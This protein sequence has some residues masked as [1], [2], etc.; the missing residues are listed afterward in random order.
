MATGYY[1]FTYGS[2]ATTGISIAYS[3][4]GTNWTP[5]NPSSNP[6]QNQ[7]LQVNNGDNVQLNFVG[8]SGWSVTG[9]VTVIVARALQLPAN[10]AQAY[11]PFSDGVLLT[12]ASSNNQAS[13]GAASVNNPG[14]G[15]M[16]KY[17]LT[18]AFSVT[19]GSS[20]LSFAEDPE[21][22]VEGT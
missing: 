15:V 9:N 3:N 14:Q 10:Q 16:N 20:T 8:P 7:V 22:D 21:M 6:N 12:R 2:T 4:D 19:N 18:V 1:Q 13:L 17:E 11:S 5:Y